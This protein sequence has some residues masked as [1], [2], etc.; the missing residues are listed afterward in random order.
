MY[1]SKISKIVFQPL[2]LLKNCTLAFFFQVQWVYYSKLGWLSN[3]N[4]YLLNI[5][6]VLKLISARNGF[7]DKNSN[8]LFTCDDYLNILLIFIK[9]FC[10]CCCLIVSCKLCSAKHIVK[11]SQLIFSLIPEQLKTFCCFLPKIWLKKHFLLYLYS[12]NID[13]YR[14]TFQACRWVWSKN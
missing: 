8:I 6:R 2:S 10:C 11:F 3:K 14:F 12:F 1:A 9:L 13:D 4:K 7:I 5:S